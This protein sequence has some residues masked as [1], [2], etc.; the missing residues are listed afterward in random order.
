MAS[1]HLQSKRRPIFHVVIYSGGGRASKILGIK[2]WAETE[3]GA[4]GGSPLPPRRVCGG[5]G[6]ALPTNF[7][8][9]NPT[10]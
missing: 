10:F 9:Q 8:G 5:E 1:G 3:E 6:V 7:C 2:A 4:G